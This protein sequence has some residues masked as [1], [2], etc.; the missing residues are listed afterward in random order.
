ML[1]LATL[2]VNVRRHQLLAASKY[3]VTLAPPERGDDKLRVRSL[4]RVALARVAAPGL[5]SGSDEVPQDSTHRRRVRSACWMARFTGAPPSRLTEHTQIANFSD[6]G[7]EALSRQLSD[8]V[9][10]GDTPGVVALVNFN[11]KDA[12][13]QTRPAKRPMTIRHLLTHTSGIG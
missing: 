10:R 6:A 8:A 5:D 4:L 1:V 7:K 12:T 2:A 13:Y 11:E 3:A 9:A